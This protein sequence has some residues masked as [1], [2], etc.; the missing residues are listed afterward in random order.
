MEVLGPIGDVLGG[1]AL[2]IAWG[3][4]IAMQIKMAE[5]KRRVERLEDAAR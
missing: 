1:I 3:V 5:L 4:I 2:L